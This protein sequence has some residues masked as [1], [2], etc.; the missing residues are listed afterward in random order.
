M[1]VIIFIF[2]CN[3]FLTLFFTRYH[4]DNASSDA[5]SER[6]RDIC[7]NLYRI[8]DAKLAKANEIIL[9]SKANPNKIEKEKGFK[10]AVA[11]SRHLIVLHHYY[12]Y[13]VLFL[14]QFAAAAGT[15][16]GLVF[17]IF[18]IF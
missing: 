3:P 14:Y 9:S 4:G 1:I 18:H 17:S 2:G 6:L 13:F 10:E 7:P 11:V 15:G 12:C 5:I 16:S 8:E